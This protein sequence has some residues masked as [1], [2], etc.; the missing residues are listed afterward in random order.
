MGHFELACLSALVKDGGL[1]LEPEH[2]PSVVHFIPARL[3]ETLI[4]RAVA[5]VPE[6]GRTRFRQQCEAALASGKLSCET[7]KL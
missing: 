5:A 4:E 6:D 2:V 7:S 1:Y 3:R